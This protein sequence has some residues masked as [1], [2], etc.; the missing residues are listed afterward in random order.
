M[1]KAQGG[2]QPLI[3]HKGRA[4]PLYKPS[5]PRPSKTWRPTP[6]VKLLLGILPG[7]RLMAT[8]SIPKGL[9][10]TLLGLLLLMLGALLA[11]DWGSTLETMTILRIQPRWSL[12]HV[13]LFF[14]AV[15]T[16]ELIRMASSLEEDRAGPKSPRVLAALLLPAIAILSLAPQLMRH[17]PRLLEA[18][19]F[20]G[21]I[22]ALGGLPGAMWCISQALFGDE[23]KT[24]NVRIFA[25]VMAVLMVGGVC[26]LAA[27]GATELGSSLANRAALAGF[28]LLPRMIN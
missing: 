11:A 16:Y 5:T 12:V 6:I 28:Q 21:L 7:L 26:A 24:K 18:L 27:L 1:S 17:W 20:A 22:L 10:Y 15:L 2:D 19:W 23:L 25:G 4:K 3:D 8:E 14:G 9:P 13:G